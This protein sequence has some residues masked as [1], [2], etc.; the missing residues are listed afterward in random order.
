[1]DR[2]RT[3]TRPT[4]VICSRTGYVFVYPFIEQFC[5]KNNDRFG[6]LA[7][8]SIAAVLKTVGRDERPVGSNPTIFAKTNENVV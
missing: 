7:E 6:D 1:M 8:W 2:R 3:K 4:D 5:S